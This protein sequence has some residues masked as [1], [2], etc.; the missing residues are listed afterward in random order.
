MLCNVSDWFLRS[1][2]LHQSAHPLPP[3][4]NLLL[5]TS[6]L[7]NDDDYDDDAPPSSAPVRPPATASKN[8]VALRSQPG[9]QTGRQIAS[10]AIAANSKRRLIASSV[11]STAT[12]TNKTVATSVREKKVTSSSSSSSSSGGGGGDL[13]AMMRAHNHNLRWGDAP[14]ATASIGKENTKSSNRLPA[15][16]LIASSRGVASNKGKAGSCDKD[17]KVSSS[18]T[19][20]RSGH[21]ATTAS[22]VKPQVSTTSATS[23]SLSITDEIQSSTASIITPTSTSGRISPLRTIGGLKDNGKR[24]AEA[25]PQRP[26]SSNVDHISTTAVPAASF[27]VAPSLPTVPTSSSQGNLVTPS[28]LGAARRSGGEG[29]LGLPKRHVSGGAALLLSDDDDDGNDNDL[30]RENDTSNTNMPT[31]DDFTTKLSEPI[32]ARPSSKRIRMAIRTPIRGSAAIGAPSPSL[33]AASRPSTTFTNNSINN[34]PTTSSSSLASPSPM[35]L[36]AARRPSESGSLLVSPPLVR[37]PLRHLPALNDDDDDIAE[38]KRAL[39]W[40]DEAKAS[41]D[42]GSANSNHNDVIVASS[43]SSSAASSTLSAPS[44]LGAARR[45]VRNGA[46]IIEESDDDD[47][48]MSS[49]ENDGNPNAQ[50]SQSVHQVATIA[51]S[52]SS[53]SLSS[54]RFTPAVVSFTATTQ[55]FLSPFPPLVYF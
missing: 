5:R 44:R 14:L 20:R 45:S 17:K 24:P 55:V 29:L 48:T 28:R 26:L 25:T 16:A 27:V 13:E 40:H 7:S 51:S 10:T 9:S 1:H 22:T 50:E 11:R 49:K 3:L 2:P 23:L 34:M 42:T 30:P 36:G 8:R 41:T 6:P 35:R 53:S 18:S 32:P 37:G 4:E 46:E 47:D 39:Q 21:V 38:T 43:T 12:L 52:S 54:R 33:S 15:A 31:R 19:T